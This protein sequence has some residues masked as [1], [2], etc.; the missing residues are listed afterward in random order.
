MKVLENHEGIRLI[1]EYNSTITYTGLNLS[2]NT[3]EISI[4][5]Y[6]SGALRIYNKLYDSTELTSILKEKLFR[7]EK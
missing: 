3:D 6:E 7:S 1:N 4:G 5:L 2:I